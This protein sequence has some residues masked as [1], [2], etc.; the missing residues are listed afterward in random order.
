MPPLACREHSYL[1]VL[2]SCSSGIVVRKRKRGAPALSPTESV[3]PPT[4]GMSTNEHGALM[5]PELVTQWMKLAFL[6][7]QNWELPLPG[8]G[9]LPSLASDAVA[10]KIGRAS[11]VRF[12][13]ELSS[14]AHL[15]IIAGTAPSFFFVFNL[16]MQ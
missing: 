12:Q 4:A 6:N 3:I 16:N 9:R 5:F 11:A 13:E 2:Y 8:G 14:K 15:R 7:G 10:Q 1:D